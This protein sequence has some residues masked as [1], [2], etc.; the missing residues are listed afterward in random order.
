MEQTKEGIEQT[1]GINFYAPALLNLLLLDQ[2]KATPG[3]RIVNMASAAEAVGKLEWDNLTGEK[4][5]DSGLTPYGT[6]KLYMTIW[7]KEL[8]QRV[9]EVDVF[10]VHP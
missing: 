4:Y 3:S 6:S 8:A 1:L 7:S 10:N 9:P 2:L 5:K